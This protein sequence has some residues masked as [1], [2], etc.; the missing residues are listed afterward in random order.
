MDDYDGSDLNH[1][2]TRQRHRNFNIYM[3]NKI[4]MKAGL[5]LLR[6]LILYFFF[7]L[8]NFNMT[9]FLTNLIG[10]LLCH[11]ALVLANFL[12]MSGYFLGRYLI[13]GS[14]R[15][16]N[17]PF[18]SLCIYVDI[19][20]NFIF[21]TWFVYG[22]LCMLSDRTG[23]EKSLN[24]NK[25]LTYYVTVIILIGFFIYSKLIFYIIFFIS[26]CPCITYVLCFDVNREYQANRRLSR[27]YQKL[28]DES[29]ED[30][31]KKVGFELE[32][33]IICATEFNDTDIVICLPC[34]DK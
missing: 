23:I 28:K 26:F 8:D 24:E 12:T 10:F 3:A 34:N 31:K 14:S 33:C 29:Y 25:M 9:S 1:M 19:L 18:P 11:E 5:A 2:Q 6:M 7:Y 30:Y 13:T 4:K 15:I 21:F 32:M 27:L 20:N 22:N 17:R 16:Q